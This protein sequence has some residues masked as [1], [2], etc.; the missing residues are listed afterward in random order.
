MKA[1]ATA[2]FLWGGERLQLLAQRAVWDPQRRVLLLA[3][4]HLGKAESF[5]A[6][7]IPLP[8]DGDGSTLNALL[9]L[10]DAWEPEQVVVLGDLIHSRLGLTG[11][12]RAKLA[13]LPELLG[14]P[15]RL[16]GGNHERGSW[17]AGLAQEPSQALGPWWLSHEPEPRTGRL[18]LCGHLHPVALLGGQGD[19]LRLSC[20][21]YCPRSERLALPAFGALTGGMPLP[22]HERQW[23][24]ADG[25]VLAA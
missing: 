25:A 12:L 23:L 19:R 10:A 9:A 14:C 2:P 3:D 18:N 5:Q 1:M 22:R 15:L 4:L 24:L 16:I 8:S 6:Q 11:E 20:F 17:I 7:G 21:S 13:A